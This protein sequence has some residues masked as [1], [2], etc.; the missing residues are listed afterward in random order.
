MHRIITH[1]A[2][3]F[4]AVVAAVADAQTTETDTAPASRGVGDVGGVRR[5]ARAAIESQ[6]LYNGVGRP[7]LIDVAGDH[8]IGKF[9]LVLMNEAGEILAGPVEVRGG[10][11]DLAE[12][13]PQVW[14]IRRTCYLQLVD[15][16]RE[17]GSALVLRP[18]LSRMVPHTKTD[19]RSSGA[20]YTRIVG[21][22]DELA[23]PPPEEEEV[24]PEEVLEG[25]EPEGPEVIGKGKKEEE[26][27]EAEGGEEKPEEE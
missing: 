7:L 19:Q 3:G 27:E 13:M 20:A 17:V 1:A 8:A 12:I 26:A 25:E 24:A 11:V 23:P 10:R 21:W 18:M 5:S 6:R 14:Q 2:A 4:V 9:D 22:R 15:R 16:D